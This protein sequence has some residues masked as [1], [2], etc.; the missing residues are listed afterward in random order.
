MPGPMN[1]IAQSQAGITTYTNPGVLDGTG[2]AFS[3]QLLHSLT[4]DTFQ[5][6]TGYYSQTSGGVVQYLSYQAIA[7]A[8][9][10]QTV[11]QV[12]GN[13][14]T[15]NASA[16]VFE[17]SITP[18]TAT[19]TIMCVWNLSYG[20]P[21]AGASTQQAVVFNGYAQTSGAPIISQY[22]AVLQNGTGLLAS[23]S[24]AAFLPNNYPAATTLYV[25][26]FRALTTTNPTTVLYNDDYVWLIEQSNMPVSPFSKLI[27][28]SSSTTCLNFPIPVNSSL[29]VQGQFV[30]F[31]NTN[32]NGNGG[33]FSFTAIRGAGNVSLSNNNVIIN[34][35]LSAGTPPYIDIVANVPT[36]SIQINAVGI[37]GQTFLLNF[38]FTTN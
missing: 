32:H 10:G 24:N 34:S 12:G 9:E 15:Y 16:V 11:S 4:T 36:Q 5:F 37:T 38:Y 30:A 21:Q 20:I 1:A 31:N 18:Q 27:T 8:G 25:C 26:A 7:Y 28:T 13:T 23:G 33:N 17:G 19:S 3:G 6:Q 29:T 14:N 22:A 2:P 35:I